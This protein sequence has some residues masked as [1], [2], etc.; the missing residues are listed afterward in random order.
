MKLNDSERQKLPVEV[1]SAG[2]TCKSYILAYIFQAL[3]GEGAYDSPGRLRPRGTARR[4]SLKMVM[5][6]F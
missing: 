5:F 4:D 2:A 3:R 1:L 6:I